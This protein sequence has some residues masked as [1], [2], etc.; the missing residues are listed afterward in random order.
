[1]DLWY[2]IDRL[3]R[4]MVAEVDSSAE[5][6]EAWRELDDF[7]NARLAPEGSP[8]PERFADSR[9]QGTVPEAVRRALNDLELREGASMED[10]RRAY[11]AQLVLYHPDRHAGDDERHRTASEVTRRLTLAYRLLCDYYG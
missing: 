10:V 6:D 4:S 7:L 11:R 2:R 3:V 5:F 8:S 1:M 9:R